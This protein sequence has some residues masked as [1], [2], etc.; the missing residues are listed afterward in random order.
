[1]D[2]IS[3]CFSASELQ[4]PQP[5]RPTRLAALGTLSRSAGTGEQGLEGWVGEGVD[6]GPKLVAFFGREWLGALEAW[7]TDDQLNLLTAQGRGHGYARRF[8]ALS[9]AADL[10]NNPLAFMEPLAA[11]HHL[12][13]RQKSRALSS[14]ID[15][16]RAQRRHQPAHSAEINAPGLATVAS[17][18]IEF[19]GDTRFEQRCAP[20]AR[21]R[22][23]QQLALQFGR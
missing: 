21:A 19:D 18:D 11:R 7:S 12:A 23:Y 13:L 8:A 16:R 10:H 17:L 4:E 2:L 1:L 14:Y 15:K 6:S 3:E 20:L 9:F 22:G 5:R